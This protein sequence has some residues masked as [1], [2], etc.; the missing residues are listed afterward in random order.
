LVKCQWC[1]GFFKK[2]LK[3]WK[4]GEISQIIG[5][6]IQIF[7]LNFPPKNPFIAKKITMFVKKKRS[8][9]LTIT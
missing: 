9:A 3:I 4:F 7:G 6:T 2:K 8:L 5:K 1:L